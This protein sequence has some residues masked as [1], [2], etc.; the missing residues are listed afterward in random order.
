MALRSA[1]AR[2]IASTPGRFR[3]E[4][5][6]TTAFH[7]DKAQGQAQD[8]ETVLKRAWQGHIRND[9]YGNRIA[10]G[11]ARPWI[12]AAGGMDGQAGT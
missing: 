6:L 11:P 4:H 3:H 1:P 12:A 9:E 8:Q 7:R 5:D 10:E 2:H